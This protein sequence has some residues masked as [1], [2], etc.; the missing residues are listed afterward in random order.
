MKKYFNTLTNE[1]VFINKPLNIELT[2]EECC[3]KI[4]TNNL[5]T[6]LADHLVLLG[7]LTNEEPIKVS[8]DIAYYVT[9]LAKKLNVT[10]NTCKYMLDV[11][12]AYSP[13]TV[14]S[15]LAKQIALELDDKYPGHI[16]ESK[17]L[18]CIEL[19]RGRIIPVSINKGDSLK[20]FTLFRSP[21]D[22]VLAINILKELYV[23]MFRFS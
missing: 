2:N 21:E 10:D 3:F 20:N 4:N 22:A 8:N 15:L 1:E 9:K 12:Q 5:S 16:R 11:I 6:E 17:Y 7:V 18:Y 23:K 13:S 19:T 14:F